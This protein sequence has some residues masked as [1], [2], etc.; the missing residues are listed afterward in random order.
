VDGGGTPEILRLELNG[1]VQITEVLFNWVGPFERF[2]LAIDGTDIDV[3]AVFGT[4]E[5]IDLRPPGQP[6]GVVPFPDTLPLG[7]VFEFI[8]RH[9]GDEW[10]VENVTVIPEPATL[11]VLGLA[12][13]GLGGLPG[14]R[15][16]RGSCH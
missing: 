15:R 5:I 14:P 7:T 9:P 6:V 4:D 16:R 11:A 2:D 1:R 3:P 13:A 10:N 8:A 12:V